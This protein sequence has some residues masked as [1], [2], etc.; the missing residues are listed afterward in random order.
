MQSGGRPETR[1]GAIAIHGGHPMSTRVVKEILDTKNRHVFTVSPE[2][3][4]QDALQVMVSRSISCLLVTRGGDLV[5][6]FSERDYI[7]KAVPKRVAPW[8]VRVKDIMTEKVICV[9]LVNTIRECMELMCNNRI[10]H[11]P[12][13]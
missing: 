10:R 6:I 5:G 2:A 3:S 11:L 4:V 1:S 9:T 13:V 8:D 12:V 7:R